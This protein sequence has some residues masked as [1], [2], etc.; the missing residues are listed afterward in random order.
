MNSRISIDPNVCHGKPVIRDT[1]VLV[2]NILSSLASG[3]TI[4]QVLEDY[5]NIEY[6]DVLAA[7]EFGSELSSFETISYETCTP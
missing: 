2:R 6:E 5:P 4:E 1:R 7:L 3:E